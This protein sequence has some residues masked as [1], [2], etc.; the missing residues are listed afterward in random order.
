MSEE[1]AKLITVHLQNACHKSCDGSY[2][3]GLIRIKRYSNLIVSRPVAPH[4]A[5]S[6]M[7]VVR[8]ELSNHESFQLG[9]FASLWLSFSCL[10]WQLLF[11]SNLCLISEPFAGQRIARDTCQQLPGA[12]RCG[13]FV[14]V[15]LAACSMWTL[16][17]REMWACCQ[18]T[19]SHPGLR[20]RIDFAEGSDMDYFKRT[21]AAVYQTYRIVHECED[22]DC[23]NTRCT[24]VKT[25]C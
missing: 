14:M 23:D 6:M 15:R 13:N 18:Y 16:N 24:R 1:S 25:F 11:Y 17:E 3:M 4:A 8:M 7:R 12:C 9:Y 10:R 22:R 20:V 2:V 5:T 19:D 21:V